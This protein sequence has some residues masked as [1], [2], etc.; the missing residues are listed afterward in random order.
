MVGALEAIR[1]GEVVVLTNALAGDDAQPAGVGWP[2][3]AEGLSARE[4][5]V[6]AFITQG[7]SNQ[8]IAQAIFL[9]INSVKT[10]SGRPI[11]RS[12]SARAS[13]AVGWG[14]QHGFE[15]ASMR[16]LEPVGQV[17]SAKKG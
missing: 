4:S 6:L 9:S 5:E 10:C 13:Q 7:L 12:G 8:E 3:Q 14:M 16:L 15:P 1:D 17:G 2:G 11:A